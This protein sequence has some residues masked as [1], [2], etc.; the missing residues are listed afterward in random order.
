MFDIKDGQIKEFEQ[1]LKVFAGRALPFA[2][3]KTLN[4]T[5]FQ[6][7]RIART[8]LQRGMVLRNRF[9]VQSVRVDQARTLNVRR[10]AATVGS[11]AGYMEDQEFGATKTKPAIP[12]SYAAGQSESAQPRTKLPRKPN[13][14]AN[15][16]LKQRRKAGRSRK[17]NNLVAV[18]QAASSS[19]KYVF[20][21][22]GKRKGLFRVTGG[23][24][25]PQVKMVHDLTEQSV[26][27]PANPWLQPAFNEAGRMLPAFYADALR[28]QLKRQ[29]LFK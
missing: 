14:L 9:T 10:Q 11:V 7:Q 15:I 8:D 26:R 19:N 28:F 20:L 2:T 6:A 1:D 4:D 5:A 23:R 25:R 27:I 17:Q 13:K 12:T 22:L 16:R 3:K 24:R 18:K 21:D 29:G